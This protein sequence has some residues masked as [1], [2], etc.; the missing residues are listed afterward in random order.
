MLSGSQ[1][2]M[3]TQLLSSQ[4]SH[5]NCTLTPMSDILAQEPEQGWVCRP[6]GRAEISEEPEREQTGG[7]RAGLTEDMGPYCCEVL[8]DKW[9]LTAWCEEGL[10]Q[11]LLEGG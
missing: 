11:Y 10:N 7:W 2:K 5:W 1:F 8:E 6:E 9:G 4:R 3:G